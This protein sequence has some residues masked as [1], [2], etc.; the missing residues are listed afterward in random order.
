MAR[1]V[2][3]LNNAGADLWENPIVVSLGG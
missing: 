1:I 3:K 2:T